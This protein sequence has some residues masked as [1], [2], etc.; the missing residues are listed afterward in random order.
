MKMLPNIES[1]GNIQHIRVHLVPDRENT[2]EILL[3]SKRQLVD[4]SWNIGSLGMI[5]TALESK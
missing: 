5:S 1:I 4:S 2:R 3:R